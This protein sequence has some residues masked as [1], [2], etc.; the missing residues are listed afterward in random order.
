[1]RVPGFAQSSAQVPVIGQAWRAAWEHVNPFMAFE[2]EVRRVIHTTSA[3]DLAGRARPLPL[4]CAQARRFFIRASP[5]PGDA[6]S[7]AETRQFRH[8]DP[9]SARKGKT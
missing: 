5:D 1:M 4:E 7:P 8:V 6:Q 2:P 9:I 3:A